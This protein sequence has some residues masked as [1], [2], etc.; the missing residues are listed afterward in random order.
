MTVLLRIVE[1]LPR[2]LKDVIPRKSKTL[3]WEIVVRMVLKAGF[4]IPF[5]S[6]YY[7]VKIRPA[8]EG[9]YFAEKDD[10][11]MF[12]YKDSLQVLTEILCLETYEKVFRVRKG[13]VVIDVG[14]HVGV[15]TI[16]AAKDC[17]ENGLVVAIEPEPRNLALLSKNVKRNSLNNVIIIGKAA[18]DHKGKAKLHLSSLSFQHSLSGARHN[19]V[20]IDIDTLDNIAFELKL[21]KIN[22][23]KIDVEGT[24]LEVLKGARKILSSP[25]V[26]LAIAAYHGLPDG[27]SQFPTILS[28]L[29]SIGMNT[30]T[31][32]NSYSYIYASSLST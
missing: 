11:K 7:G 6:I 2:K 17:G 19:Y 4:L 20:W 28:H 16:K 1:V 24:E 10:M 8:S 18:G 14:A 9:R 22:F 32:T 12:I 27:S 15:F 5:L 30:L 31:L 21:D 13:D 26:K 25:D 23:I 29:K 3:L